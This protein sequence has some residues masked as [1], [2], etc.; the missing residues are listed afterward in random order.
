MSTDVLHIVDSHQHFWAAGE[1]A[2]SQ[3]FLP[4]DYLA[5]AETMDAEVVATVFV[6]CLTA[7]DPAQPESLRST[8][9]TRFAAA[10]GAAHA[11]KPTRLA[12]AIVAYADPMDT[13]MPFA[14]IVDA[15][16]TA[17]GGRLR[18][19]RRSVAWDEDSSL[20][21][22]VLRTIPRMLADPRMVDAAHILADR[23]LVFETWLYH[24]QIDEL[25]A[26]ARAAPQCTF[27]LDHAG[28]P[29]ASGRYRDT[30]P[31]PAW[32]DSMCRL[33]EQPNVH[34]KIG[35]LVTTGTVVDRQRRHRGLAHWT[36]AALAEELAPFVEHMLDCFGPRRCLFESN[37]PV[38]AAH[39]DLATLVGAYLDLTAGLSSSD[40]QAVF[41]A[42]AI[43]LYAIEPENIKQKGHA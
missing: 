15:H 33:A 17:A 35:G 14:A 21:Y 27:I 13:G 8:G 4:V 31:V 34:V 37:F 22:S 20:N 2:H 5:M 16:R 25:A 19:I 10:I 18:A 6:E 30:D 23:N 32:R 28:T 29:L 43:R 11:E 39:C 26:L 36:R 12:A 3:A 41:S 24:P 7:Y 38:D 42:N 40:R 9:E 1:G